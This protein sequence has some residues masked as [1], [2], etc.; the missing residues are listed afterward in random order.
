MKKCGVRIFARV[1]CVVSPKSSVAEHDHTAKRTVQTVNMFPHDLSIRMQQIS[2]LSPPIF[3]MKLAHY[4]TAGS[5]A[6]MTMAPAAMAME[7]AILSPQQQAEITDV[8]ARQLRAATRSSYLLDTTRRQNLGRR[9]LD[10]P[11]PSERTRAIQ[12]ES[13]ILR[14]S[15]TRLLRGKLNRN[16]ERASLVRTSAASR[17]SSEVI[18][19]TRRGV[20]TVSKRNLQ[21]TA[22]LQNTTK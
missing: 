8:S 1:R 4:I 14:Q 5:L 16:S 22:A 18:A 12:N 9:S 21:S 2:Y 10:E 7:V 6:F 3:Q 11:R 13:T 17:S 15:R 20:R 19:R